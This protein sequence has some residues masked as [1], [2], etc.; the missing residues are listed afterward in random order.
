MA[1]TDVPA[2]APT[3]TA[4]WGPLAAVIATLAIF[5]GGQLIGTI[6]VV[7]LFTVLGRTADLNSTGEAF[8]TVFLFASVLAITATSLTLTGAFL[9]H[10][11][12][13]FGTIGLK[14]AR[15][16]DVP[17]AIA[18]YLAYLVIFILI[19]MGIQATAPELLQQEQNIG[20]SRASAGASLVP[21]FISLVLLPPLIEEILCR[22]LL[23]TGLRRKLRPLGATLITSLLFATAHLQWDQAAPLLWVA[24]IDTFVLS[25]VLCRLRE[26]T[27]RLWAPIL[28]HGIK[29]AVAF[30]ALFI[31][32]A[33]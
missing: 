6:I 10:K 27:G 5:F 18:G 30:A 3:A 15:L 28:V 2:A 31:F 11:R 25:V 32:K 22:G 21:I 13:T 8:S 19:S 33:A 4:T 29:N 9:R 12:A 26:R 17:L 14:R 16:Q 20:F 1:A 23:Y 7:V 24:A